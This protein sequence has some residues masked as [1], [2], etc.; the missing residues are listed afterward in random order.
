[1]H[2]LLVFWMFEVVY[3]VFAAIA[4]IVLNGLTLF[5]IYKD[6]L[7]CF[8]NPLTIFITGVLVADFFTGLL[9]EITIVAGISH[10]F[11]TGSEVGWGVLLY[12]VIVYLITVSISFYTLLA[13]AI[14]QLLAIGWVA[15]YERS[16]SARS[17][18]IGIACIWVSAVVVSLFFGLL[19]T[20]LAIIGMMIFEVSIITIALVVLYI[21]SYRVFHK[22]VIGDQNL[23]QEEHVSKE[24]LIGTLLLVLVQIITVWPFIAYSIG[25]EIYFASGER[26]AEDWV[27][28]EVVRV[29]C[30]TLFLAKFFL[31]PI[32]LVWRIRKYRQSLKVV[33]ASCLQCCGCE[34][35]PDGRAVYNET[36][37]EDLDE[38]SQEGNVEVHA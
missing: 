38:N 14:C 30:D 9:G 22:R 37:R 16:V 24:F 18:K 27:N 11:H 2:L 15:R 20:P 1:M 19:F 32:V 21:V 25:I 7:K 23:L 33:Y 31:D 17:A 36:K 5:A 13:L 29:I 12:G 28:T 26:T 35:E 6:P 4:T 34:S 3:I 10:A 8:R